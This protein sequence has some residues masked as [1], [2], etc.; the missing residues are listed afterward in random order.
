LVSRARQIIPP[1]GGKAHKGQN[2]KVAVLGGAFEYTGAPYIAA[3]AAIKC[4][5][6]LGYVFCSRDAA[7]PIKSYGPE[8]I[9]LPL[10]RTC[11]EQKIEPI[12]VSSSV[13]DIMDW[14][15]R[16]DALVIGPGLGRDENVQ[17]IIKNVIRQC[18]AKQKTMVIDAD[19]LWHVEQDI[20]ILRGGSKVILTP[21]KNEFSRLYQK[22]YGKPLVE[23]EGDPKA[24]LQG[25]ANS[26]FNVTIVKKGEFDLISNGKAVIS[27]EV[28]GGPRRC[29]GIGDVL[30]GVIGCFSVWGTR[31]PKE[32]DGK[33]PPKPDDDICGLMLAGYAGCTVTRAATRTAFM[34]YSR[35]V[36]ANDLIQF[37]GPSFYQIFE[38]DDVRAQLKVMRNEKAVCFDK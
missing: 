17:S 12:P 30:A 31:P 34:N 16:I 14:V 23:T 8:L 15:N 4:G 38:D 3:I 11:M 6:D 28:P 24:V 29:G 33:H 19:G 20:E 7:A 18:I 13:N 21:N 27:C 5:A 32:E 10:L 36:V 1:L 22:V 26:L 37:I 9:V 35:S 2:G 25:L